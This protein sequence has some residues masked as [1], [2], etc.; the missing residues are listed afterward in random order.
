[1]KWDNVFNGDTGVGIPLQWGVTG[2]PTIYVIDAEGRI[3]AKDLSSERLAQFV[4][5]LLAKTPR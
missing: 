4:E 1:M 3:A 2:Y 5:D